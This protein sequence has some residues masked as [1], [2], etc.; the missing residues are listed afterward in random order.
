MLVNDNVRNI[1]LIIL[2]I[3]GVLTDGHVIIDA[4]GN[5]QKQIYF[6]DLDA[7]GIGHRLGLEFMIATG[8][9]NEL[10]DVIAR[11]FCISTIIRGAKDKLAELMKVCSQRGLKPEAVC[12]VGDSD[13]D[14]AAVSWAGFG[15]APADASAAA[16]A[17]ADYV[18]SCKGGD[19]VLAEVIELMVR[20][21]QA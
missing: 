10:A 11:R 3:D 14:A 7:V 9:N 5:E 16:K 13:R 15:V 21:V 20:S 1:K 19:G 4:K 17:A 2:D 18:T 12:Y 8:E 6:R